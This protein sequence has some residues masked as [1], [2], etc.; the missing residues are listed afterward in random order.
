MVR[1]SSPLARTQLPSFLAQRTYA[2]THEG[3]G[4]NTST[5]GCGSVA[6]ALTTAHWTLIGLD[7][8]TPQGPLC[9]STNLWVPVNQ[10]VGMLAAS[11]VSTG[12]TL[13]C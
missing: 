12:A 1:S 2:R 10:P 4:S 6:I 5:P 3:P 8:C 11:Q 13:R 9:Q 7:G